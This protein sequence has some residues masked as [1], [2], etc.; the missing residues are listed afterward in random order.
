MGFLLL[1]AFPNAIV[2]PWEERVCEEQFGDVYYR[3]RSQVPRWIR[4][5]R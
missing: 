1:A 4:V 5:S 3:Y 2:I